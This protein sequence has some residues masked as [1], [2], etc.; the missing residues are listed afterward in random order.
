MWLDAFAVRVLFPVWAYSNS[1][2]VVICISGIATPSQKVE[3][4]IK[5]GFIKKYYQ[6]KENTTNN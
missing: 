6:F 4:T 3:R 2:I 1:K 5:L